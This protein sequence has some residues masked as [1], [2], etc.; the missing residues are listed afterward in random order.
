MVDY[1]NDIPSLVA[2]AVLFIFGLKACELCGGWKLEQR[3]VRK[4]EIATAAISAYAVAAWYLDPHNSKMW[5][6][7]AGAEITVVVFTTG[8]TLKL[9]NVES[10]DSTSREVQVVEKE[11]EEALRG[12]V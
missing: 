3:L 4:A 8:T 12:E 10:L 5:Q 2:G 9:R 7:A 1:E 11:T 6:Y